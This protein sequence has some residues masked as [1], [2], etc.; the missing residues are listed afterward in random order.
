MAAEAAGEGPSED[1]ASSVVSLVFLG[2]I[3]Y[4]VLQHPGS[5]TTGWRIWNVSGMP[6]ACAPG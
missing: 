6:A 2:D 4:D 5:A 3:R 1:S